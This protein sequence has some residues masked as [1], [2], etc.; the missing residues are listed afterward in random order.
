MKI[1]MAFRFRKLQNFPLVTQFGVI[2]EVAGLLIVFLI[3]RPG[4]GW[5]VSTH[6]PLMFIRIILI[7]LIW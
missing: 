6:N 4:I 3:V 1:E 7:E 2:Y 5:S